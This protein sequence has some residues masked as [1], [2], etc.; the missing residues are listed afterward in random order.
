MLKAIFLDDNK[1]KN[2]I[3]FINSGIN[4]NQSLL[5]L[6]NTG[7]KY[8]NEIKQNYKNSLE[9]IKKLEN[10]IIVL[11]NQIEELIKEKNSIIEEKDILKQEKNTSFNEKNI[12]KKENN[13]LEQEKNKLEQK[14]EELIQK[15]DI[16]DTNIKQNTN[17]N[18]QTINNS[19]I[20]QL[21]IKLTNDINNKLNTQL[22]ENNSQ[23]LKALISL[24]NNKPTTQIVTTSNQLPV[25]SV[26]NNQSFTSLPNSQS[27]TTSS[28][29]L[30]N[31]LK[32]NIQQKEKKVTT[33]RNDLLSNLLANASR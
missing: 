4:E 18:E 6:I 26:L 17:I 24:V 14:I 25:T 13:I 2:I 19:I 27:V 28:S 10:Q 15:I 32:N 9:E 11:N 23:L 5:F 29:S 21:Y 3:D 22:L 31:S 7:F 1:D 33:N 8:I 20:D 30:N 12:L 16:N